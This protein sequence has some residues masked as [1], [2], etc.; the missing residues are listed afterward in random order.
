MIFFRATQVLKFFLSIKFT[1]VLAFRFGTVVLLSLALIG[2][3]TTVFAPNPLATPEKLR[4]AQSKTI[5]DVTVTVT[6][7]TDEQAQQHFGVDLAKHRLQA[8]WMAVDN[9]TSRNLWFIRNI[10]DPD[11]Y[12]PEEAALLV[13]GD[14]PDDTIN[15]LRQF[16]RDESLRVHMAPKTMTEG[17]VFLPRVEGGRYVDIRLFG[18]V[19]E[20]D[21]LKRNGNSSID[22]IPKGAQ[23]ELR[24]DFALP[25]PDGD[26]DYEHIDPAHVYGDRT[27]PNHTIEELRTIL[28]QLPCCA[29]DADGQNKGDPLNIVLV[30]EANDVLKSLSRSGWSFTHRISL[31]TVQREI[32]SAISG[33]AYP[34]APVSSL[35]LFGRKQDVALQ[36]AR[37][38]IAQRNHMRLWLAPFRF[39]QHHVWIGQVSRDIGIKLT[40]KSPTLVTH[41]IDPEVDSTREYLLHSLMAEGFVDRFGFVKGSTYATPSRPQLN[42]TDDPYFSDGMRLVVILAREP[43]R[44]DQ[45]R[46]LLWEQSGF[47]IAEGQSKE[48]ERN[49]HRFQ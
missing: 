12:S 42:L 33:A 11:F 48:A 49:V 9:G 21:A 45:I 32:S 1:T 43:I 28:E 29:S 31:R 36:R 24:F 40:T 4:R 38:S 14:V 37:S 35:Y 13:E 27:L 17:F 18:D 30:G 5:D 3:A 46:S 16:F 19:F 25:L 8:L 44:P 39:E 34:I 26:F 20:E 6:I 15:E 2:C 22:A 23:R 10:L 47:P 41:A 7:L